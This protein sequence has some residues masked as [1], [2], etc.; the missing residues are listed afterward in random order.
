M[1]HTPTLGD[2]IEA[3]ALAGTVVGTENRSTGP[4]AAG[5]TEPHLCIVTDGPGPDAWRWIAVAAVTKTTPDP[6]AAELARLLKKYG[7]KTLDRVLG[8]LSH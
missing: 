5:R 7:R 2:R 1:I 6:V 4:R 3:G 8:Q